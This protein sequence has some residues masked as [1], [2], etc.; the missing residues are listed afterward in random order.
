M[1]LNIA[2]VLYGPC[3]GI[4]QNA[5]ANKKWLYTRDLA[6]HTSLPPHIV[7]TALA[8][9][10]SARL[11]EYDAYLQRFKLKHVSDRVIKARLGGVLLRQTLTAHELAQSV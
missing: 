2:G 11:V 3:H 7:E 10:I 8:Q 1:T 4:V 9:M 5:L 6:N